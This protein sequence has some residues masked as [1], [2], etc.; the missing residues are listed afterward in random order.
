VRRE[1]HGDLFLSGRIGQNP[2]GLIG[3]LGESWLRSTEA[4]CCREYRIVPRA[5]VFLLATGGGFGPG[6]D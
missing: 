2:R 6:E 4:K 5:L 1:V 3:Y